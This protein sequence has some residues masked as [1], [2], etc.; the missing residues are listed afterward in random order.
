MTVSAVTRAQVEQDAAYCCGYCRVPSRYVYAPMTIDH[1]MPQSKGGSDQRD[2]LWLACPRCN[3]FKSDHTHAADPVTQR[4]VRLFNPR[5]QQWSRHFW[6]SHEGMIWGK[7]LTGRATVAALH[8]NLPASA[9]LRR[10][11]IQ[12][13]WKP[14]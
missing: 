10:L 14:K 9:E 6:M 2:N 11:L 1:I 3:G 12:A 5:K 8:L 4:R 13:G 7:T